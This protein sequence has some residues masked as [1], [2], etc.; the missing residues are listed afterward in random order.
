MVVTQ[1]NTTIQCN[2]IDTFPLFSSKSHRQIV[3]DLVGGGV[4]DS[5]KVQNFQ[6]C[7]ISGFGHHLRELKN[8]ISSLSLL[9]IS[10]TS[11]MLNVPLVDFKC[12]SLNFL[13]E[14]SPF[15]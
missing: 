6:I 2:A 13:S 3:G 7:P 11:S 12:Y 4:S 5:Q 8:R 15:N 9:N 1:Y 14:L 10:L